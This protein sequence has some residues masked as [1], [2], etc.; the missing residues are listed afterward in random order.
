MS[1]SILSVVL[2]SVRMRLRASVVR[3]RVCV[4]VGAWVHGCMCVYARVRGSSF[5]S[6]PNVDLNP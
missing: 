3:A 5:T 6:V 4:C 2:F 1:L